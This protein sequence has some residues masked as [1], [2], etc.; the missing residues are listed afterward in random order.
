MKELNYMKSTTSAKYITLFK[1]T[2][3]FDRKQCATIAKAACRKTPKQLILV[4]SKHV[5]WARIIKHFRVGVLI[6]DQLSLPV[7]NE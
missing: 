4:Y 5:F 6:Y 3:Q 1:L 7:P 2:K